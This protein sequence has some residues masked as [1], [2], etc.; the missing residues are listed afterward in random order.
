MMYN[1][2]DLIQVVLQA[3]QAATGFIAVSTAVEASDTGGLL[4]SPAPTLGI[5]YCTATATISTGT[6]TVEDMASL[7]VASGIKT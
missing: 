5:V 3:C 2:T 7:L 6:S 4:Q 1:G